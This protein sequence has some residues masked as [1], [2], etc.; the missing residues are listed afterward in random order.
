MA[1]P[2][3]GLRAVETNPATLGKAR[4]ARDHGSTQQ[5]WEPWWSQHP[6]MAFQIMATSWLTFARASTR[7]SFRG[8]SAS[9]STEPLAVEVSFSGRRRPKYVRSPSH[10]MDCF[11]SRKAD[12]L[13]AGGKP[14]VEDHAVSPLTLSQQCVERRS[15][16]GDWRRTCNCFDNRE[17]DMGAFTVAVAGMG[18]RKSLPLCSEAQPG[19]RRPSNESSRLNA[20]RARFDAVAGRA[21]SN[22]LAG[23]RRDHPVVDGTTYRATES[24]LERLPRRAGARWLACWAAWP[25]PSRDK[26]HRASPGR[27]GGSSQTT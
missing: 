1:T 9:C 27:L 24:F 15:R 12:L 11:G 20:G 22:F 4:V 13:D 25:A 6:T 10:S 21:A 5:Q 7:T 8:L 14:L 26:D 16:R 19:D 17:A 18:L 23:L 2:D 3:V